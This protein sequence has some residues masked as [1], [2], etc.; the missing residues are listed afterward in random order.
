VHTAPFKAARGIF[1]AHLGVIR[2]VDLAFCV[3]YFLLL[4]YE[5]SNNNGFA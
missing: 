5:K 1:G 2:S 3:K 4:L